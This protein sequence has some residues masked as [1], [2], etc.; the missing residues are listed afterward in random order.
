MSGIAARTN[1][2]NLKRNTKIGEVNA[3]TTVDDVIAYD[4][5]TGW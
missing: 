5:T 4:V 3:L 1:D 2:L